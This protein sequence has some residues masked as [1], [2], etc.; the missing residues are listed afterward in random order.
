MEERDNPRSKHYDSSWDDDFDDEEEYDEEKADAV[1]E[2]F[3]RK[4]EQWD[5]RNWQQWLKQYVTFPFTAVREEDM[6]ENPFSEEDDNKPFAVGSK[7]TVLKLGYDD[8]HEAVMAH[9]KQGKEE[10]WVPLAD[11]QVTP[12]S[13][14]NYWAVREYVVWFANR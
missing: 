1:E 9:V 13:D 14:P 4:M 2:A 8:F 3:D 10:G 6:D 7:M 12:K 5:K 11:L